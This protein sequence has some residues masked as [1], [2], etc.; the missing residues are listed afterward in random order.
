[1]SNSIQS[2]RRR[3]WIE[4]EIES[5]YKTI[6][7]NNSEYDLNNYNSIN[8]RMKDKNRRNLLISENDIDTELD[9]KDDYDQNNY[10]TYE[11]EGESLSSL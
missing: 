7:L 11:Y 4:S 2:Q 9:N 8:F 6:D 3:L 5:S 1:M 10:N